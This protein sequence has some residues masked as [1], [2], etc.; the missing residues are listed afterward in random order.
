LDDPSKLQRITWR[1]LETLMIDS[2]HKI[3]NKQERNNLKNESVEVTDHIDPKWNIV[4]QEEIYH[5]K[6]CRQ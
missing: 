6:Y 5:N 2:N 1:L 4:I 3:K